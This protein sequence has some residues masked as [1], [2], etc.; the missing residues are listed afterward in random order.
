MILF[1]TTL[2]LIIWP[3]DACQ[4]ILLPDWAIYA[5]L[6]GGVF[7]AIAWIASMMITVIA[8]RKGLY[9]LSDEKQVMRSYRRKRKLKIAG[10]TLLVVGGTAIGQAV[11]NVAVPVSSL[12]EGTAFTD[13]ES[14]RA[15]MEAD[16]HDETYSLDSGEAIFIENEGY[17]DYEGIASDIEWTNDK[18]ETWETLEYTWRNTTVAEIVTDRASANGDWEVR[19]LTNGDYTIGENRKTQINLIWIIAYVIETAAGI[20]IYL[21]KNRVTS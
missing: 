17:D 5:L 7:A 20:I 15:Y 16:V 10:I 19:V 12:V 8:E 3:E 18:G 21:R 13:F 2:P 6:F 1:G 9:R 11:F 14:F 4:G